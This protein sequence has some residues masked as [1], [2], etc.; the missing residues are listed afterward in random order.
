MS[1]A[2]FQIPARVVEGWLSDGDEELV[3][4]V[5]EMT[6]ESDKITLPAVFVVCER[7]RGRGVHDHPAFANGFTRDDEFVDDDFIESYMRGDYDVRCEECGGKRVTPEVVVEALTE[8]QRVIW[9]R[10]EQWG[11]AMAELR[12]AERAERRM[13]A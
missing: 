11:Q 7:C 12:A 2:R 3:A 6:V 13:G 1:D 8:K 4:I 10:Y 5:N 9:D